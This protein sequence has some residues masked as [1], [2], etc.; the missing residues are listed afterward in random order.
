M[1]ETTSQIPESL[2]QAIASDMQPVCP[3]ATPW[4]RILWV[5][6]LAAL[7][8]VLP[9]LVMGPRPD[10]S[11]L[12]LVFAWLPVIVQLLLGIGFMAMALREAIPGLC[13]SRGRIAWLIAA[14]CLRALAKSASKRR[15]SS[16]RRARR[17]SAKAT[18]SS[19]ITWLAVITVRPIS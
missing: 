12:G 10:L 6:P 1:S 5:V 14:V 13:I 18:C 4:K 19:R 7:A 8:F 9:M 15:W 11:R 16:R 17:K 2:R 3:L